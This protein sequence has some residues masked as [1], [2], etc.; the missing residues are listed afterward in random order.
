MAIQ[1]Y[2]EAKKIK[3]FGM[4]LEKT[5]TIVFFVTIV[6]LLLIILYIFMKNPMTSVSNNAGL[7]T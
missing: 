4:R 5:A 7:I 1:E 2:Q 6:I 3:I